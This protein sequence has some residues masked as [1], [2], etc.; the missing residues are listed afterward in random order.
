MIKYDHIY[1]LDTDDKRDLFWNSFST[2]C[3]NLVPEGDDSM[4]LGQHVFI[5]FKSRH[6]S[7]KDLH[8]DFHSIN[9]GM[10][11]HLLSAHELSLSPTILQAFRF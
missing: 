8:Q 5:R 6:S 7:S 4:Q 9:F 2:Y 10:F 1:L 11:L 3:D